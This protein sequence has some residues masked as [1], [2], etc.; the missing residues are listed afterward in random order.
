[1][2]KVNVYEQHPQGPLSWNEVIARV[3]YNQLLDSWDGSDWQN[4]GLGMHLGIT[5]LRDGRYVLI[6]GTQWTGERDYAWIATDEE[7]LD[8]I[9]QSDNTELLER[10]KF[11]RLKDLAAKRLI[12][13]VC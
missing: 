8:A 3:E 6:R 5:K 4:G 2:P 10:K 13:E 1:M 11:A 12:P 7:A 9:L